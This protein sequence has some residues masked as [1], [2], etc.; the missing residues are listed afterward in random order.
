MRGIKVGEKKKETPLPLESLKQV[1]MERKGH[2]RFPNNYS[3]TLPV[4]GAA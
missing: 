2:A 3:K 1:E 4:I